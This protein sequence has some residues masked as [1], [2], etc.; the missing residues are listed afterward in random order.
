MS[1]VLGRPDLEGQVDHGGSI[2]PTAIVEDGAV[3]GPGTSIWHHSHVRAGSRVGARCTIGFCVY[4]DTGVEIGDRCKVQNL[5]SLYRGVVLE[6]DVFIGPS[7]T[8][9][10]DRHPRADSGTWEVVSTRVRSGASV[11][12]NATVICGVELGVRSMVGAGAVVTADVPDH[13]MVLGSPARLYAW[14][15]RCGRPLA[16]LGDAM[17]DRC[18]RCGWV[19]AGLST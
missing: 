9:T 10:N 8:F 18:S 14:V 11:G 2:H 1:E 3:V 13:G 5:V 12:A 4:V 16:R 19:T 7:V 6:D 15:C 17:P